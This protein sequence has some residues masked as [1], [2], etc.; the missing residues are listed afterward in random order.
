MAVTPAAGTCT[1][2]TG[3]INENYTLHTFKLYICKAGVEYDI[4]NISAGNF[5]GS[6]EIKDHF[7]GVN[8]RLD[9]RFVLRRTLELV[10]TF[11]EITYR[12]LGF[13]LNEDP[14]AVACGFR[15]PLTA[16]TE[17]SNVGARMVH[18]FPNGTKT[19][20]V[21]FWLANI[22]APFDL[23]FSDDLASAQLT[24]A[25]LDCP[26]HPSEPYGY[27]ELGTNCPTS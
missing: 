14:T 19:L 18:V 8:G 7:N 9:A 3:T 25:A 24:I 4:G 1:P 22:S 26:D 21:E 12:N 5:R 27:V 20:T 10:A 11:E 15:I 17:L 16:G 23:S 6:P 2:C 13:L